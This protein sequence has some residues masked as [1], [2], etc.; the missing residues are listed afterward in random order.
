M[1]FKTES[2]VAEVVKTYLVAARHEVYCEVALDVGRIDIVAVSRGILTSVEVKRRLSL[3]VLGQAAHRARYFHR[4]VAAFPMPRNRGYAPLVLQAMHRAT[5]IGIWEVKEN[6]VRELFAPRFCRRPC[7]DGILESL[8]EQQQHQPAGVAKG[9]WSPFKDTKRALIGFVRSNPGCS[10]KEAMG[11][12]KHHYASHSSA[13]NSMAQWIRQG[14][15]TEI[16]R[17][18]KGL[19][20]SRNTENPP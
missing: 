5:G 20:V 1:A 8:C 7:C 3:D 9:F 13:Y 18:G 11:K 16:E 19:Y 15:I 10:L 12:V 14:V 4:S 2:D 17:R 6:S